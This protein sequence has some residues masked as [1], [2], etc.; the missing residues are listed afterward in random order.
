MLLLALILTLL[1]IITV[2][3]FLARKL[4]R[5]LVKKEE[6]RKHELSSRLQSNA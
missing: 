2:T 3:F 1:L 6:V 5:Q 4:T